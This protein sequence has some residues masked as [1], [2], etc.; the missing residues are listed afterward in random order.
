MEIQK[1]NGNDFQQELVKNLQDSTIKFLQNP[2][3]N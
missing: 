3:N 1:L 2:R